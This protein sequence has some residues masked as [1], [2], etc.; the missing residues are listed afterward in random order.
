MPP[1]HLYRR[2]IP[3]KDAS[4]AA[5]SVRT[6]WFL[7]FIWSIS[8]VSF[9]WLNQIDQMLRRDHG[10]LWRAD[11]HFMLITRPHY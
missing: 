7:W 9:V 10:P 8:F 3:E 5:R 1:P 4:R 6:G 11:P 2:R